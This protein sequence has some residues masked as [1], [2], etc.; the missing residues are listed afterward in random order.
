M[1]GQF[2]GPQIAFY[3]K[4]IKSVPGD[5]DSDSKALN[6]MKITDE[7]AAFDAG[8]D[9]VIPEHKGSRHQFAL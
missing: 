9:S 1:V 2:S 8:F 4:Q 5:E 7:G 3:A 6:F